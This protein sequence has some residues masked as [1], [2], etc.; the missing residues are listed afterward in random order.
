MIFVQIISCD[1][2]A[3]RFKEETKPKASSDIG[4]IILVIDSVQW[5]NNLGKAMKEVLNNPYKGLPQDEIQFNLLKINPKRFKS[6]LKKGALII[7]SM[8]LDSKTLE[9]QTIRNYFTKESLIEIKNDTSKWMTIRK[10]MFANG[11]TCLF[12]FAKN[13][14][15]LISKILNNKKRL[16]DF[17]ESN[18]LNRIKSKIFKS[19]EKE[20]EKILSEKMDVRL[21]VPFGWKT[22]KQLFDFCW[23]RKLDVDQDLSLFIYKEKYRGPEVFD[24][25]PSLR[26]KITEQYLRDSEKKSLYI[27]RQIK[28]GNVEIPTFTEIVDFK[29]KYAF[30]TKGLWKVSDNTSGGPYVSYTI[31][32]ESKQELFYIEGYVYAPGKKKKNLVREIEAILSTF[33]SV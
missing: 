10:D 19:R 13:E 2:A 32:D 5:N 28:V 4:E 16:I 1:Q 30:K 6:I 24:H 20:I 18:E 9:S 14:D 11:Q 22:A 12:L 33:D 8:T 29:G 3:K 26:D 27:T 15:F 23:I 7:F 21:K 25:I 31:V 17:L